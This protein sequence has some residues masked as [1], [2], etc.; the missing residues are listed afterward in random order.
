MNIAMT[1]H[2]C[3]RCGQWRPLFYRLHDNNMEHLMYKCT[4]SHETFCIPYQRGLNIPHLKA[5]KILKQEARVEKQ[6]QQP[7]LL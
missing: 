6:H 3:K 2:P 7:T 5:Q 4:R 1:D